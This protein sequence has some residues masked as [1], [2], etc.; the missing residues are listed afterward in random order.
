MNSVETLPKIKVFVP[1]MLD[2]TSHHVISR[3]QQ[4]D[5]YRPSDLRDK[6]SGKTA[7]VDAFEKIV[8]GLY[9]VLGSPV[10][11]AFR[12]PDG[13]VRSLD[14]GCIKMLLNRTPPELTVI[15]DAEGYIDSVVPSPAMLDRYLPIRTKLIDRIQEAGPEITSKG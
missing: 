4:P 12:T 14:A 9:W 6:G 10:P 13:R 5:F 3:G 15:C 1:P 11:Y 7:W 2:G 8:V